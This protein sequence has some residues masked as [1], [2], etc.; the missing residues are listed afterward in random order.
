MSDRIRV[1]VADDEPIARAGLRTLLAADSN[2]ELVAEC[3]DGR[4]TIETIR[5]VR[6]DVVFLDVQMPDVDGFDVLRALDGEPLPVVVFVTA[7]DQYAIRA[8]EVH[9]LDYLLKPFDDVRFADTLARAKAAARDRQREDVAARLAR[10]LD[11]AERRSPRPIRLV[12]KS[13]GRVL[14]VRADEIDWIEAADYYVKLHVAGAVHMLRESMSALEERLD[15]RMFFR[16]HR[17]AI[18][19]LERVRELQPFSRR[20]YALV[21]RDGTRLRI[22]ARRR[23][24]LEAL[25]GGR[26]AT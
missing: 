20:E 26:E 6:P 24:Q 8:F 9:A 12:V 7:Y 11:D 16:A 15:R 17:S 1:V 22:N 19:N 4:G 2:V 3:A 21:L 25:L 5:R 14:F 23:Q 18:V 13:G 10:L